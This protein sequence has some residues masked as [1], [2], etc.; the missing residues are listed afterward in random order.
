MES[1]PEPETY[2]LTLK[3]AAK[4]V[5]VSVSTLKKAYTEGTLR[6]YKLGNYRNSIIR[7]K[8]EDLNAWLEQYQR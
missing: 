1:P 6:I 3:E 7:V 2:M 4:I 8:R 5:H